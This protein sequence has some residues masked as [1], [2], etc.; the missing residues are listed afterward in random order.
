MKRLTQIHQVVIAAGLLV[1]S[2]ASLAAGL[3]T[4]IN[5]GLEELKIRQHHVNVVIEDGYAVTQVEQVF[6]N[7]HAQ[8]L[9]AVYSFPVPDKAA[10]GEF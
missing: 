1:C 5:S 8:D 4:P 10:V 7:P 9:E 3:M 6:F 2:G